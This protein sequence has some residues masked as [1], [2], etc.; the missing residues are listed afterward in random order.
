MRKF[1]NIFPSPKPIEI[2]AADKLI[3]ELEE[4]IRFYERKKHVETHGID[5][6]FYDEFKDIIEKKMFEADIDFLK[7]LPNDCNT[8]FGKKCA[9]SFTNIIN[10]DKLKYLQDKCQN[11]ENNCLIEIFMHGMA[12]GNERTIIDGENP[13]FFFNPQ[14]GA[15]FIIDMDA[16][17]IYNMYDLKEVWNAQSTP[18]LDVPNL[19]YNP[20]GK[21]IVHKR[22]GISV[23]IENKKSGKRE[24]VFIVNNSDLLSLLTQTDIPYLEIQEMHNIAKSLKHIIQP[25]KLMPI[26]FGSCHS[27]SKNNNAHYEL[28]EK[29]I[30]DL[31]KDKYDVKSLF[32]LDKLQYLEDD[33]NMKPYK[34]NE[35]TCVKPDDCELGRVFNIPIKTIS[36]DLYKQLYVSLKFDLP[37]QG[38]GIL[39]I[40]IDSYLKWAELLSKPNIRDFFNKHEM[41]GI[42]R[43]TLLVNIDE[44]LEREK[45]ADKKKRSRILQ[46]ECEKDTDVCKREGWWIV[47]EKI[48]IKLKNA[49]SPGNWNW[50]LIGRS[51][52]QVRSFEHPENL[53]FKMRPEFAKIIH[54]HFST[55]NK[56]NGGNGFDSH[57]KE[58]I[59]DFI[60]LNNENMIQALPSPIDDYSIYDLEIFFDNTTSIYDSKF[61][62]SK[63]TIDNYISYFDKLEKQFEEIIKMDNYQILFII[64]V[65]R[66]IWE[67]SANE[68]NIMYNEYFERCKLIEKQVNDISEINKQI[69]SIKNGAIWEIYYKFNNMNK[70]EWEKY[71]IEKIIEVDDIIILTWFRNIIIND[72]SLDKD[73]KSIIDQIESNDKFKG[74]PIVESVDI[75]SEEESLDKKNKFYSIKYYSDSLNYIRQFFANNN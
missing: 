5:S 7:I 48:K 29:L 16:Y 62:L 52:K 60:N 69:Q 18:L 68:I 63:S 23:I 19:I 39:N 37:D 17:D 61:L 26:I 24:K 50:D 4:K 34:A 73:Y 38:D 56:Q 47:G 8:K 44:F 15:A 71:S 2:S 54:N 13:V 22:F 3:Y 45:Q 14:P 28:T 53:P 74:T 10:K 40:H 75:V 70:E 41:T 6:P 11:E 20:D 36:H 59:D 46:K 57:K 32:S 27:F 51:N 33:T 49:S 72:I 9:D 55:S 12:F 25:K 42:E 31:A 43:A 58:K 65:S 35:P 21:L 66:F 30:F 64:Y 1:P 67:V